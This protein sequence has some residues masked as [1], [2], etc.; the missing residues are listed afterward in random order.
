MKKYRQWYQR[1]P[2]RIPR[3]PYTELVGAYEELRLDVIPPPTE[4]ARPTDGFQIS[5]GR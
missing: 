4:N 5:P 3:G 1:F 2:L